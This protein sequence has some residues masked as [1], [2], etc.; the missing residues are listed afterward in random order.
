MTFA[1]CFYMHKLLYFK[2][3]QLNYERNSNIIRVINNVIKYE[4][5]LKSKKKF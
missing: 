1:F 2:F 4:I 3:K 5:T